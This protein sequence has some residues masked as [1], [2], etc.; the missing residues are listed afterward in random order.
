MTPPAPA[1]YAARVFRILILLCFA[2]TLRAQPLD[3][4]DITGRDFAGLALPLAPVEGDIE[5]IARRAHAWTVTDAIS[6]NIVQRLLL[7]GDVKVRLSNYAFDA[8]RAAVWIAPAGERAK[9]IF[10][11]FDRVATPTAASGFGMAADRLPVEAV[12]RDADGIRMLADLLVQEPPDDSFVREGER[13]LASYLRALVVGGEPDYVHEPTETP[14]GQP[15]LPSQARLF[16]P[17]APEGESI[18]LEELARNLPIAEQSDPIFAHGGLFSFMWGRL[19][20]VGGED[21]DVAILESGIIGQYADPDGGLV[22]MSA[23]R[24]V[25]FLTPGR[26]NALA[27]GAALS[28]DDVTGI[29]LE[30]DVYVDGSDDRGRPYAMRS[31]RV[32]YDV[33]HRRA[34]LVDAVFWTHDEQRGLTLYLRA[35]ALRQEARS[36][37]SATKATLS[38]TAFARPHLG[39]GVSSLTVRLRDRKDGSGSRTLVDARNLVLRAADVPFFYWPIFYGDPNAIPIRGVAF[40]NSNATGGVISTQ[41]DALALSGIDAPEGVDANL[42]L[43]AYFDRGLGIGIDASVNRQDR[44]GRLFAYGL[45]EDNGTDLLGPGTKVDRDGQTRSLLAAEYRQDVDRHWSYWLEG[46]HASDPALI[47]ALFEHEARTHREFRNGAVLTRRQGNSLLRLEAAGQFDD[48]VP[49]QYL[50]QTPGYTTEKLPEA[51]FF[52]TGVDL[53]GDDAPGLATYNAE[54]RV[55]RI[56]LSLI[57]PDARQFGFDN[58]NKANNAFGILPGQSLADRLRA[59]GYT[60]SPVHRFDTRHEVSMQLAAGPV[61]VT[62]FAVARLTA[63]DDSFADFSPDE[64]DRE[65]LW[66]AAGVTLSTSIVNVHDDFNSQLL[67]AHR[68]RHVVEPSLTLWHAG[69]TVDRVHLP[70]YDEDVEG[71]GEGTAI[72]LGLDQTVQTQRGGPGRWRSIDLF[73]HSSRLMIASDDVDIEGR[74]LRLVEFRPELSNFGDFFQTDA[75]WRVTETLALTGGWVYDLERHESARG[76]AGFIIQHAADFSLWAETRFID[77]LDSTYFSAGTRQ[78]LTPKYLVVTSATYDSRSD[79]IQ[80]LNAE[81]ERAYPNIDLALGLSF[82][83][84]TSDTSFGIRVTPRNIDSRALRLQRLGG[85]DDTVGFGGFGR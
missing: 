18:S 73:Q 82:N 56:R 34:L 28:V 8:A 5:F 71:I 26:I 42:L 60:E 54:Y 27:E 46:W 76:N 15:L 9:Q 61:N 75:T 37:F 66:G 32:Y 77:A 62:P 64:S 31:P 55:S 45:P 33:K 36:Q 51:A 7:E 22:Q 21:A 79:Q 57:D 11:Y 83:N 35:E 80:A 10:V 50:L 16:Q 59:E 84:I 65:R 49:N 53:M 25:I 14:P 39:I 43:D 58:L 17:R 78:R 47:D 24:A 40:Q 52:Q 20:A 12:I 6:G 69:S 85:R 4:A 30:G 44:S 68:L 41:W 63:Y 74:S 19:E 81:V 29:Y 3:P 13:A 2:A 1:R 48:F 38:N 67:D 23:E 70:V 72:V